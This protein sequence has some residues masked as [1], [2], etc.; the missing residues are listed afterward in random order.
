MFLIDSAKCWFVWLI[1]PQ[2][3]ISDLNNIQNPYRL[4][5]GA[6]VDDIECLDWNK[7][8]AHI[9]VTGSNAGFVTIW[10]VKSRKESLTLNNMGRKAVSAVAWDPEK[11]FRLTDLYGVFS[12][13]HQPTK[14]ITSTP[15]ESDPMIYV[16]DLRNSHAPER[17]K[18]PVYLHN[19]NEISLTHLIDAQGP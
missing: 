1:S 15:L 9:L 4:G 16:W 11:V 6:R 13:V 12:N 3:Y 10:D 18:T 7:K 14:V 8:V 17:V 5:S 19:T 2:L